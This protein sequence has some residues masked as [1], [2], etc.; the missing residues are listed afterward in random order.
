MFLNKTIIITGASSGLGSSLAKELSSYKPNLVLFSRN[1]EKLKQVENECIAKGAK[2]ISVSGD[3]T[4]KDDCIKL[5]ES[6]INNFE[7]IDHLVLNAGISMWAKFD[8]VSD[9]SLF[10]KLIETNY[11]SAVALIN[12]S[13][14]YLKQSKGLVIAISSIQG[15]VAVPFHSGYVASKHALTGFLNTLRMELKS[16]GVSVMLVKPHWLRGTNLR[17]NAFDK[18]GNRIG[19]S[20][21]EHSKE[22]ISL[23]E[24]SRE[25][26]IGMKNRKRE[27]YIPRKLKFLEWLNLISPGLVEK[28]VSG[29]VSE[30]G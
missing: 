28:I 1:M 11:L 12:F 17:K 20:R 14:T 24:C 4:K 6:A 16:Y 13:L 9:L 5:I 10:Q 18:S 3:V 25:I 7:S 2:V 21:K 29:K 15:N 27:L 23:E 26:I 22:S 8:E 19:E 30:Q